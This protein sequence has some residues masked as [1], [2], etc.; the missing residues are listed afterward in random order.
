MSRK[1]FKN[2]FFVIAIIALLS[3][4]FTTTIYALP[5]GYHHYWNEVYTNG[6]I[7]GNCVTEINNGN[8]NVTWVD[9][10][11]ICIYSNGAAFVNSGVLINIDIYNAEANHCLNLPD[12]Y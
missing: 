12:A 9:G 10:D 11:H 5:V 7:C 1:K 2:A 3:N 8:G 4:A 6:E